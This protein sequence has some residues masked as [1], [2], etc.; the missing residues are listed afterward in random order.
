MSQSVQLRDSNE[1]TMMTGGKGENVRCENQNKSAAEPS[2]SVAVSKVGKEGECMRQKD[3]VQNE[4]TSG[5]TVGNVLCE[6]AFASLDSA[7]DDIFKN[8]DLGQYPT[9]RTPM[10]CDINKKTTHKHDDDANEQGMCCIVAAN[11]IM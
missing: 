3:V 6:T 4:G 8:I 2:A 5:L 7:D 10:H 1:G 9:S 11:S